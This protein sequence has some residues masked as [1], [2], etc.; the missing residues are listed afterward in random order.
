MDFVVCSSFDRPTG[1]AM[2]IHIVRCHMDT[3]TKTITQIIHMLEKKGY[4]ALICF[5]A[6]FWS[7]CRVRMGHNFYAFGWFL[8]RFSGKSLANIAREELQP[9]SRGIYHQRRDY[10]SIQ[11][12]HCVF[13]SKLLHFRLSIKRLSIYF[14][15]S[16]WEACNIFRFSFQIGGYFI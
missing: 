1:P 2:L 10:P 15:W 8:R 3:H 13:I 14:W 12:F 11:L 16:C 9:A 6:D 5:T 4:Y 7:C